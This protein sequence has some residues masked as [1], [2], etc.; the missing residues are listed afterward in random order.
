VFIIQN[1]QKRRRVQAVLLA[2]VIVL[3]TVVMSSERIKDKLRITE[4][5]TDIKQMMDGNYHSSLGARMA[6][7]Q[8]AWLVF[9]E[10]PLL[11]MGQGR[12]PAVFAQRMQ[13]GEVPST[14]VYGQPHSDI[15]HTLSSGGLL[16]FLA[17]LGLIVA[18]FVFFF[19]QFSAVRFNPEQRLMPILGMQVVATYF[20]TGLTNSNFDLQIYS[21]TYAVLV[22]VLAR[23][24]VFEISGVEPSTPLVQASPSN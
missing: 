3:A 9:N 4:A 11:G 18:P 23:L 24:S 17:Y 15:L 8:T 22:C 7:W 6:M 5:Q 21:T 2:L 19:K 1:L 12:F 16:R 10:K 13:D 14:E 20:L